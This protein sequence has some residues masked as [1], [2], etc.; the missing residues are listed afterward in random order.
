VKIDFLKDSSKFLFFR[1]LVSLGWMA[2]IVFLTRLLEPGEYGTFVLLNSMILLS[3][4]FSTTWISASVLRFTIEYKN[5]ENIFRKKMVIIALKNI[6]IFSLVAMIALFLGKFKILSP[7]NILVSILWYILQS[8]FVVLLSF[9]RALREVNRYGFY[10]TWQ[11]LGGLLVGI[12]FLL[13]FKTHTDRLFILILGYVFALIIGLPFLYRE[14]IQHTTSP[15]QKNT[16]TITKKEVS[17]FFNYGLG[18]TI[19]NLCSQSISQLD[20]LFITSYHGVYKSGIY[21]ASYAIA[22]QSIF[23]IVSI[24]STASAPI[25]YSLWQKGNNQDKA[26]YFSNILRYYFLVI[27]PIALFIILMYNEIGS[28]FLDD[29]FIP[30]FNIIPIVT[31]GAVFVGYATIY[32]DILTAT[33]KPYNLMLCYILA[34][35]ANIIGNFL[36]IPQNPFFGASFSTVISYF[37][38]LLAVAFY[39]RKEF[40]W[41][42]DLKLILKICLISITVYFFFMPILPMLHRMPILIQLITVGLTEAVLFLLLIFTFKLLSIKEIKLIFSKN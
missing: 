29:A 39:S 18:V 30:A 42:I 40:R 36:W 22:E 35:G 28:F 19:I 1:V 11:V 26:E 14:V 12:L 38:L 7:S 9:F 20:K 23:G 13:I 25:V 16:N 37:I 34:L 15:E 5:L 32:T 17:V 41:E 4:I 27:T 8:L 21:S 33:K 10:N 31:I 24:F 3:S 2:S 6:L